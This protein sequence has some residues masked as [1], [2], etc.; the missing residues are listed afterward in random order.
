MIRSTKSL[1]R[2]TFQI[3]A[4]LHKMRNHYKIDKGEFPLKTMTLQ[5]KRILKMK[6]QL[7]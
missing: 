4:Q 7:G 5:I 1:L 6:L 3:L 2:L